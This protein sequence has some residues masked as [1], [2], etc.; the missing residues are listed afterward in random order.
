MSDDILSEKKHFRYRI[1]KETGNYIQEYAEI[2]SIPRNSPS[3]ALEEI[4]KEHRNTDR[5]NFRLNVIV[6]GITNE[7]TKSVQIALQ[8]SI[9]KEVNKVRLGTN[10]I[11]RNTQIIIE[12]LQGF[13]QNENIEHI[14]TTK[15]N[16][17]AFIEAV[18][19]LIQER[20]SNLKQRKHS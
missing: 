7:V 12:L 9:S 15:E 6:E 8:E 10:N 11:D 19:N 1:T 20:I 4:I 2:N 5:E 16:E 13:M 18:E 14:I 17:P 3:Q